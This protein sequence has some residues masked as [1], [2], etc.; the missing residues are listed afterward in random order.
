LPRLD[1][2]NR[3]SLD[4]YRLVCKDLGHT[5]EQADSGMK[6]LDTDNSGFIE[7]DEFLQWLGWLKN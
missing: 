4:E 3:L 6:G 1:G 2:D 7:L 5:Q